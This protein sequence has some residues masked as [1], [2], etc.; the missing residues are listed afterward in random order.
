MGRAR[1]TGG[2]NLTP[3]DRFWRKTAHDKDRCR[4]IAVEGEIVGSLGVAQRGGK[5]ERTRDGGRV[6]DRHSGQK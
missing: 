2:E 1:L 3:V 5:G 6:D 4:R